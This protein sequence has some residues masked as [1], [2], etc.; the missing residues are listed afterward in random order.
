MKIFLSGAIEG[1]DD[2]G[3]GWRQQAYKAFAGTQ[4]TIVSP[5][6]NPHL[7][8]RPSMNE[9]V[10]RNEHL[11]K[12]CDIVLAEYSIPNRCYVGTDYELVRA[13]DWNQ[14]TVVWAHEM[15]RE[16]TY[17]RYL[18]TVMVDSLHDAVDYITVYYNH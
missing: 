18:S 10:H 11:Q 13:R 1:L 3:N 16:R 14:P 7:D 15:Y 6:V 4:H 2:L 8:I 9:I 12:Q 17:L 5:I